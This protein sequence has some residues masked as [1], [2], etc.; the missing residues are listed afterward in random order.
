M[1]YK[2]SEKDDPDEEERKIDRDL[3]ITSTHD[4]KKLALALK[5]LGECLPLLPTILDLKPI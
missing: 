1:Y 3:K 2:K 5:N 4:Y